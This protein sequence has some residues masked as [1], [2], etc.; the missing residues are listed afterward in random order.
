MLPIRRESLRFARRARFRILSGS[1]RGP[2]SC[3]LK[4]LSPAPLANRLASNS[5]SHPPPQPPGGP[6]RAARIL[7]ILGGTRRCPR[8]PRSAPDISWRLQPLLR[9][10]SCR[11]RREAAKR[12]YR[13]SAKRSC[14]GGPRRKI[15][16]AKSCWARTMVPLILATH[17]PVLVPSPCHPVDLARLRKQSAASGCVPELRDPVSGP[18]RGP[19]RGRGVRDGRA[20]SGARNCA[21]SN[22]TSG[23]SEGRCEGHLGVA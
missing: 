15:P 7:R 14:I 6:R 10:I 22:P 11:P 4:T 12:V 23:S 19:W 1:A 8:E 20:A 16:L 2:E 21:W 13:S 18:P 9:A 3:P 5:P 17:L